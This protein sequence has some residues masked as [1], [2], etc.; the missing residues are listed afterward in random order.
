[1]IAS[2][3]RTLYFLFGALLLS[4]GT[5]AYLGVARPGMAVYLLNPMIFAAQCL[6]YLV[7]AGRWL[8]WRSVR[9]S[10]IGQVLAGLLFLVA[11]SCTFL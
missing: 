4:I 5:P 11:A 6:P 3:R 8:P 1:M 10:T 7:A 9:A 2:K